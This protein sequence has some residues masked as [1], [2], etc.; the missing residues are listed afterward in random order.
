MSKTTKVRRVQRSNSQL[1]K[2]KRAAP[3]EN[4]VPVEKVV[5]PKVVSEVNSLSNDEKEHVEP[6][7]VEKSIVQPVVADNTENQEVQIDVTEVDIKGF[8]VNEVATLTN[9]YKK[10]KKKNIDI[11]NNAFHRLARKAG[12]GLISSSVYYIYTEVMDI[13][14]K[15][16]IK[17]SVALSTVSGNKII[18]RDIFIKALRLE[19]GKYPIATIISGKKAHLPNFKSK[20]TQVVV[21]GADDTTSITSTSINRV[22]PGRIAEKEIHEFQKQYDVLYMAK[23]PFHNK[24]KLFT[25]HAARDIAPLYASKTKGETS[26]YMFQ[27][28]VVLIAQSFIEQ[29]LLDLTQNALKL[30]KHA[31]RGTLYYKDIILTLE[32]MSNMDNDLIFPIEAMKTRVKI[33]KERDNRKK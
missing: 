6:V 12:A 25:M 20:R 11:A 21:G 33:N 22:N 3:E 17:K 30:T 5:V 18:K 28:D 14:L 24:V 13:L 10:K 27:R 2:M 29:F 1:V 8:D 32:I 4:F 23:T 26:N 9:K 7:H 15:R 31:K 16:I 19:T